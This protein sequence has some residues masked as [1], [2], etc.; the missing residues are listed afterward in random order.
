MNHNC[1]NGFDALTPRSNANRPGLTTLTYRVG[2]HTTFLETMLARLSSRDLAALAA[3]R[4]RDPSDPA[5]AFLDAWATVADVLSFYQERIANEGY[6]RTATER[7]SLLELARLVN[8]QLRPGVA[9]SVYLA[10]TMEPG[11]NENAKVPLGTRAQSVPAPG[12][13]PQSFET[14]QDIEARTDWN[15]LQPRLSRPQ[16][17]TRRT[18]DNQPQL[19]VANTT[20]QLKPNDPL[21]IV[22]GEGEAEQIL[23]QVKT[24]VPDLERKQTRVEFFTPSALGR[25]HS[26]RS[27]TVVNSDREIGFVQLS[28]VQQSVALQTLSGTI[29]T[30]VKPPSLPPINSQQLKRSKAQTFAPTIDIAPQLLVNLKPSIK[31]SFYT[32]WRNTEVPSSPAIESAKS[33]EKFNVKASPFGHNAPLKPI[34]QD[35]QGHPIGYEE[36]PLANPMVVEISLFS[37]INIPES[38]SSVLNVA[39][40]LT[41]LAAT[42]GTS[43]LQAEVMVA[44][45]SISQNIDLSLTEEAP[46]DTLVNQQK[47]RVSISNSSSSSAKMRFIHAL[48]DVGAVDVYIRDN[49]NETLLFQSIQPL[50]ATNYTVVNNQNLTL[51]VRP[52]GEAEGSPLAGNLVNIQEAGNNYSVYAFELE[53]RENISEL[54]RREIARFRLLSAQKDELILPMDDKVRVKVIN[55]SHYRNGI[56]VKFNHQEAIAWVSEFVSRP[57]ELLSFDTH[58]LTIIDPESRAELLS[59]DNLRLRSDK[60]YSIV[61]LGGDS[62]TNPLRFE[63]FESDTILPN[64]QLR[65]TFDFS[66]LERVYRVILTNDED[67]GSQTFVQIANGQVV[68]IEFVPDM[69]QRLMLDHQKITVGENRSNQSAFVQIREETFEPVSQN[70]RRVIALDAQYDEILPGSW[71]VVNHPNRQVISQVS[72]VETISKA[73]YGITGKVTQL[74]LQDEWL[75]ANDRTLAPLRETTIYAQSEQLVLA[76]EILDPIEYAIGGEDADTSEPFEIELAGLYDG[77]KPGQWLIVSGERA[78][79]QRPEGVTEG[80]RASELV[81]LAGVRQGV[82]QVSLLSISPNSLDSA[83][84]TSSNSNASNNSNSNLSNNLNPDNSEIQIDLPGDRTHSFLQLA[85]PLAYKYK[86]D[87]VTIYGNVVKATHGETRREVLGSGDGSKTLQRFSLSKSPLT[88]LS[89]PT[90]S[91]TESTL[92]VRVDDIEWHEVSNLAA[93]GKRDRSFVTQTDNDDKTHII[94]GD[95]EHGARLP[96]GLE[97]VTA[98]YRDGIGKDGNVKPEQIKLLATRPLGVKGVINPLAATGGANRETL[99]QAKRNVPITVTTL[100]RLVSVQDYANFARTYA[101]IA[102]ADVQQ[103]PNG[104]RQLIHLTIAGTDN[105]PISQNSD[106]YRNLGR[107]LQRFGDPYQPVQIAVRELM[108]LIVSAR[109]QILPDY[110]WEA[111]KTAVEASLFETFSFEH[112][113]LGQDVRLSEVIS[114][115]Q[116]VPGVAYVDVDVL[117][118][119]SESEAEDPVQLTQ[120]LSQLA[121]ADEPTKMAS[122]FAPEAVQQPAVTTTPQPRQRIPVSL[123][124]LIPGATRTIRPAQLAILSPELPE[125][126]K[127]E[128]IT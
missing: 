104:R 107:S 93:A 63:I 98:V 70:L 31:S 96:S 53:E 3:L 122:E 72:D 38:G 117:D 18:I 103:F 26:I 115:I 91:G 22:F 43:S 54:E 128:E 59:A 48:P 29:Q 80:V 85:Q 75:D 51:I 111:V 127:L 106:L 52:T 74:T 113:D 27:N 84:D 81:M 36:W 39:S 7:R 15:Q 24:V 5:I 14:E 76:E 17:I 87:T 92:V 25:I 33:I 66:D 89:A 110:L 108:L 12:E 62:P 42:V 19:F 6:L 67:A 30:L 124:N 57:V 9:S 49:D 23:R 11:F 8:Y 35:N 118:S 40:A 90:P 34:Y 102:K 126:L 112:R 56:E 119:V 120:K 116:R 88:H 21:L 50:Q 101:G 97:N 94:F 125:T 86:R 64:E 95:G 20:T 44:T 41:P 45:G 58:Q 78:D 1:C 114:T 60:V 37:R 68:T 2:T 69:V 83:S 77:L 71:V 61:L 65:I 32:A 100:D 99:L 109:I 123:A 46:I 121:Q 28:Q 13:M 47:V 73:E 55:A 4:T 16:F 10:F 82:A 79:I 105:I